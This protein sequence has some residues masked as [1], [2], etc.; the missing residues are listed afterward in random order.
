MYFSEVYIFAI[1]LK[2]L[3]RPK[4]PLAPG[5]IYILASNLESDN[6]FIKQPYH[7]VE[8][9]VVKNGWVNYRFCGHNSFS[10]MNL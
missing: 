8:V 7:K 4:L 10:K 3:F 9:L 1:I 5:Q 6:P 2:F